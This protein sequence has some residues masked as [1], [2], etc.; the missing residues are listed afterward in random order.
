MAIDNINIACIQFCA[1]RD[2]QAN[3]AALKQ[4][5]KEAASQGAHYIQTPE[6]SNIITQDKQELAAQTQSEDSNFFL[7]TLQQCAHEYSIWLHIGS[8]AVKVFEAGVEKWAN[9]AYMINPKGEII[10]RYDKIHLF[11]VQLSQNEGYCESNIYISGEKAQLVD[12]GIATIG[13][14]I[15]YDVRFP[16][17]FRAYAEQGAQILTL[18]AAFTQTTA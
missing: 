9:R 18:P 14:A 1:K 2:A 16:L 13:M 10:A 5:I 6:M 11:D 4:Y 3:L 15:C 17:L 7:E 8:M 12:I